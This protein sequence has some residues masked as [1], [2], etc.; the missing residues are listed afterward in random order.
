MENL[1]QGLTHCFIV[2]FRNAEDRDKYLPH[3]AHER[4][5]EILHPQLEKA[6]VFDFYVGQ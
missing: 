2:S 5:K 6:V 1:A 3:P 4:F